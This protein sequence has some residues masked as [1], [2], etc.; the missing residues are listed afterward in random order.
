[1]SPTFS[2]QDDDISNKKCCWSPVNESPLSVATASTSAFFTAACA[3]GTCA[4]IVRPSGGHMRVEESTAAHA[5]LTM[6]VRCAEYLE[7]GAGYDEFDNKIV[8]I[9]M[10][11]V[12]RAV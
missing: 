10:R 5:A 7:E 4:V 3:A 6:V 8:G 11:A 2:S 9:R 1:M 12:G